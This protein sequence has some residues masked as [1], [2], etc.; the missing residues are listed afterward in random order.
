M[1]ESPVQAAEIR[2]Q[3]NEIR[4]QDAEIRALPE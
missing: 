2:T 4:T 1:R 3:V